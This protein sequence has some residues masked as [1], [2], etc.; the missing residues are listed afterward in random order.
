[1]S[2]IPRFC[3]DI[4]GPGTIAAHWEKVGRRKPDVSSDK[5]QWTTESATEVISWFQG[6]FTLLEKAA[7][8]TLA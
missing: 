6:A 1:M 3:P 4:L 8:L 5:L 7:S 2:S